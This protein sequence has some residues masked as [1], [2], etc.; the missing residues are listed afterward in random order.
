M[1][2]NTPTPSVFNST[3]QNGE[4]L[5]AQLVEALRESNQQTR[6]TKSRYQNWRGQAKPQAFV[7][8]G[9]NAGG[10][11]FE[12]MFTEM[13]LGGLFGMPMFGSMAPGMVEGL[14]GASLTG[15]VGRGAQED[16][17]A[18]ELQRFIEDSDLEDHYA[19]LCEQV[20]AAQ[21]AQQLEMTRQKKMLLLAMMALLMQTPAKPRE[22]L[23]QDVLR[24]PAR[25]RFKQNRHSIDCIKSAFARQADSVLAPRFTAP[26]YRMAG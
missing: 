26:K 6:A 12:A 13:V 17:T 18:A 19:E 15:M 1:H 24:H 2:S 11:L 4:E 8:D 22:E 21:R 25:A 23:A 14:H 16:S 7:R 20:L 9:Q 5:L 3:L 10:S